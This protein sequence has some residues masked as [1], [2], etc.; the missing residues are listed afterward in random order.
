MTQGHSNPDTLTIFAAAAAKTSIMQL[1]TSIVPT[2]PRHP[3]ALAQ[4]ALAIN[5][6][7]PGRFRLGIGPSHR[8]IIEGVYGLAC[9][10]QHHYLTCWNI[11]KYYVHLSGKERSIVT[12][13][14]LML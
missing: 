5:D 10:R 14:S 4:Q 11:C 7:A 12:D 1:G 13:I 9:H 6:I 2:Y 8:L 3:L